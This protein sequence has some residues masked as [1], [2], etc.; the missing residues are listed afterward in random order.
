[1]E[2]SGVKGSKES[3]KLTITEDGVNIRAASAQG[4]VRATD[5]LLQL[6]PPSVYGD[7]RVD[8][9]RLPLVEIK[10]S[11]EFAWRGLMLDVSRHVQDKDAVIKLLDGMAV[12]KLNVFH[13]H[14]TDDQGWRLPIEGYP[15]LTSN[16]KHSY[17]HQDIQEIV[18]HAEKLGIVIMPEIDMP[19]H[20]GA[21]CR[22][23]P[24]IATKNSKGKVTGTMNPG[25]DAT[26]QFIETVMKDVAKQFP[27]SPNIHIGAD[28]VGTGNW[29]IDRQCKD[30]MDREKLNN[31]RDLKF[32]FI[33]RVVGI[34][35]RNGREAFAWNEAAN[36]KTDP[37]LN[38][39]S[40]KGMRPGIDAAKGGRKVVFS[41]TPQIYFDHPNT[42]S[43]KNPYAY[44]ANTSYLNHCYFFNPGLPAVP[45]DKRHYILGGE[46]CLWS[47]RIKSA[48]H[49]FTM[50]FPRAWA[51][52]ETLWT[53]RGQKDW[54]D[55]LIRA[56]TQRK[57]FDA[58]QIPYF[59]E[60][61]SLAVNIG[62]WSK[63]EI[64]RNKGILDFP[65]HEKLT[66]PGIQEFFVGQDVGEGQFLIEKM[67]MLRN[68][69][70]VDA[71]CHTY[72]SSVF[73]D[74]S[75]LYLLQ[76]PDVTAKYTLRI[77]LKR[78]FGDCAATVQVNPALP[79]GQYSKQ[80]GPT[81]GSN[82]TRQTK[83]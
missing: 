50:M 15:K 47:E 61:E 9:I 22:A 36:P 60:P 53:S 71:D 83:K 28:E 23:Y 51:I 66:N 21:S 18:G 75:S 24:E 35:K 70:V 7:G 63:G 62:E 46:A 72:E 19:G 69:Q 10:D 2:I 34:V 39:L 43:N 12:C 1:L 25:A 44:S 56:E 45:K 3:Y 68:G 41:P 73:H 17:T 20:S 31:T 11:P 82:R 38:I 14:L 13:W 4:V 65:L 58:M 79:P 76:T 64:A 74:A 52:G 30:L 59:W 40:W 6:M 29:K 37:D 16:P 33:N 55:F 5:T 32:Y 8:E 67:E 42:R 49:M 78:I 77:H 54:D 81:T 80:C 27:N 26:Y 48:D 57:R